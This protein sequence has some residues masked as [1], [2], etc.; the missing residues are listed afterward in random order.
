[1]RKVPR[2]VTVLIDS[3]EQ[4]PLLFPTTIEW[5]AKRGG[6]AR[7]IFIKCKRVRLAAGDYALEG[8]DDA[9]VETK[10]SLR[11]LSNNAVSDDRRRALAALTRF[12]ESYENP[13]LV[14]ELSIPELFRADKYV[15][16]PALVV[17]DWL[18]LVQSTG[19]KLL[20]VGSCKVAAA[21]R[22]LGEFVVRLLLAHALRSGVGPIDLDS[23]V[24]DVLQDKLQGIE[25]V[26][27]ETEEG[28][29][30]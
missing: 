5:Y 18:D 6:R 15:P 19:I 3:R 8:Y 29:K 2:E 17:D 11:E 14:W 30:A 27:D 10:R 1:M 13:Y 23:M 25:V 4:Y 12:V 21:R 20:V 7:T 24:D 26:P 16:T 9:G 22:Q 28:P